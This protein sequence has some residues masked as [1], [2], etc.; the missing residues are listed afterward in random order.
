FRIASACSG[1]PAAAGSCTCGRHLHDRG[2]YSRRGM[3]CTSMSRTAIASFLATVGIVVPAAW[4]LL[5]A[6]IQTD[7]KKLRPLQQQ[8]VVDGARVTLD[9]DR[10]VVLTGSTLTAKLRAYSDTPRTVAVDLTL[11]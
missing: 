5:D 2:Q 3:R 8:L 1:F 9:V 4:R 6:N 10:S 11:L 7:G